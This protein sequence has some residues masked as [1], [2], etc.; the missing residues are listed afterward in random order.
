MPDLQGSQPQE[1]EALDRTV[2]LVGELYRLAQDMARARSWRRA[3]IAVSPEEYE[4]LRVY[5][6]HELV[7]DPHLPKG[8]P[9]YARLADVPLVIEDCPTDPPLL[10]EF[11]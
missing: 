4:L 10:V 9:F 7:R 2:A 3:R 5:F 6:L 8:G 1:A 11:K